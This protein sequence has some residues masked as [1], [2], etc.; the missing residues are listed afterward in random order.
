[1]IGSVE[2]VRVGYFELVGGLVL[3]ADYDGEFVLLE[4]KLFED[5]EVTDGADESL[6]DFVGELCCV[7]GVL[8][9]ELFV[10]F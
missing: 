6:V 7:E 8:W 5:G 1:M 9:D 3:V 2:V 10:C 4:E